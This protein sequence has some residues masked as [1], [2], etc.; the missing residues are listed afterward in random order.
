VSAPL[1]LRPADTC[2][3]DVVALGEVM[4]RF[5]PGE[6]RVRTARS[7]EV[8]EGGGEYNVGRALNR[9]FGHR[10]ATIT[11]IGDN[12]VGRLL[13]DLL[14]QGGTTLDHVVWKA[15][16]DV[17]RQHR[18]PLNFT[19]RGFGLRRPLGVSD[20]AHSATAAMHPGDVDWEHLFGELG[21]RWFHTGGIFAS[22]SDSTAE[23]ARAAIAA[24]RRHGT[25]VSYDV[26]YRPSLWAASGGPEAHQR[27]T[28]ELIRDVDVVLGVETA[29]FDAT[30]EQIADPA[31]SVSVIA[32]TRRIV[33]S[34]SVH[35]WGGVA[36]SRSTGRIDGTSYDRVDVLDRV[37]SGDAFA[38]GFIHGLLTATTLAEALELGIAH[39]A[40]AMTTPGDT[41]SVDLADVM[42]LASGGDTSVMR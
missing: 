5:D 35:D 6:G 42:R 26:N 30:V 27:L 14:L 21:A 12:E 7:F 40:L 2:R 18:N 38:S 34:A 9:V 13:E 3:Y 25:V 10:S 33:R 8:S 4:L 20:R 24:A 28:S 23:T 39:G 16:D 19:E 17:G 32:S 15:T 37:G 36:W 41:S 31:T 1:E 11:A 22:L 29:T